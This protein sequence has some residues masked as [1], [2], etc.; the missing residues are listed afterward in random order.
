VLISYG[1]SVR[2]FVTT[3][4]RFKIRWDR[5]FGFSPY[6][7][8]ESTVFRDKISCHWVKGVPTEKG[9]KDRHPH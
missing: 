2:L 4:Y 9:A 8:L 5:D 3:R 1:N 7:S 6:D